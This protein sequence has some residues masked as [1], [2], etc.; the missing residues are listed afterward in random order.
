MIN[1][2]KNEYRKFRNLDI[3]KHQ[4]NTISYL[5]N[6]L[7]SLA[8]DYMDLVYEHHGKEVTK[9]D[10]KVHRD[11]QGML[12]NAESDGLLDITDVNAT[13]RHSDD[14]IEW[15]RITDFNKIR[16]YKAGY[17]VPRI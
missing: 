3:I 12:D 16:Y 14:K 5:R 8:T 13:I 2:I 4:R 1:Y 17:I 15:A 6:E 11:I 7:D 9:L 10:L